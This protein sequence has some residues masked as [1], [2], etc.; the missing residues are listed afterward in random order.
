MASLYYV[1]EPNEIT[2][3]SFA[4]IR[5]EADLSPLPTEAHGIALR[6]I[7]ACGMIDIVSELVVSPGAIM[8]GRAALLAGAPIL[9]DAEMVAAG[10]TRQRLPADNPVRCEIGTPEIGR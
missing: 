1:R 9:C 8:A 10:I 5:A 7:H 3:R 6:M 2:R 4:I